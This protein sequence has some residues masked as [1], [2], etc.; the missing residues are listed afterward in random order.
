MTRWNYASL[1]G[2]PVLGQPAEGNYHFEDEYCQISCGMD[3]F[4]VLYT[5]SHALLVCHNHQWVTETFQAA[6]P[7]CA[8]KPCDSYLDY[9]VA[10]AE[11]EC[12]PATVN[13]GGE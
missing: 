2:T 11:I 10:N 12:S 1:L 7:T 13:N 3:Q 9:T 5:A 4:G 6:T 8:A